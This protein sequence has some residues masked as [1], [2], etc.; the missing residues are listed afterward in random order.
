M[1]TDINLLKD[2]LE[3]VK[4]SSDNPTKTNYFWKPTGVHV[5]RI[6]PYKYDI[7]N[8]FQQLYFHYGISKYSILSLK[9]F[10]EID[11]IEVYSKKLL[12]RSKITGDSVQFKLAK[13]LESKVRFF[14]PIIDLQHLDEGVKIWAFGKTI[15]TQL[16]TAIVDPEFGYGDIADPYIGHNIKVTYKTPAEAK[17]QYGSTSIQIHPK[18]Q[19]VSEDKTTIKELLDNQ[20]NILELYPK[21]SKEELE[22]A[23]DMHLHPEKYVDDAPEESDKVEEFDDNVTNK[24]DDDIDNMLAGF[25]EQ[26]KQ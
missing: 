21:P 17:N 1:G 24:F 15:Y 14:A 9:T 3:E 23:L 13:K 20:P 6:L 7:R 8:P 19:P 11:P 5:I 10:G 18:S 16:L 25:D 22:L 12:E 2:L 26:L 4:Q